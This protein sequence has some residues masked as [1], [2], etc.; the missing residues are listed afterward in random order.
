MGAYA[1]ALA[2]PHRG[3]SQ[4]ASQLAALGQ[5]KPLVRAQGEVLV[6]AGEP[7]AV[8]A[9]LSTHAARPAARNFVGPRGDNLNR[10]RKSV[11][12]IRPGG[13]LQRVLPGG[14]DLC[15]E[16]RKLV[17]AALPDGSER[18]RVPGQLQRYLVRLPDT[19]TAGHSLDGQHGPIYTA[20]RP[21]D[22]TL[23]SAHPSATPATRQV[24]RAPKP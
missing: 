19:I 17:A 14:A 10:G 2:D 8:T 3:G 22:G 11:V 16:V 6:I 20:Q 12:R 24:P 15:G 9:K 23:T 21:H 1:D 18:D 7:A 5:V 4:H 13:R